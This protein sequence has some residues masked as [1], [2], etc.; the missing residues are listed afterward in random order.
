MPP[1]ERRKKITIQAGQ[2]CPLCREKV[3]REEVLA[4]CPGCQAVYHRD[5]SGELASGRCTTLGCRYSQ[6]RTASGRRPT[7]PVRDERPRRPAR[8]PLTSSERILRGATAC[9]VTVAFLFLAIHVSES[10]EANSVK[11]KRAKRHALQ[12]KQVREVLGTYRLR[13]KALRALAE[14]T[15]PASW[16]FPRGD[17]DFD[18]SAEGTD[19]AVVSWR[20]LSDPSAEAPLDEYFPRGFREGLVLSTKSPE[21]PDYPKPWGLSPWVKRAMFVRFVVAVRV[22]SLQPA[23]KDGQKAYAVLRAYLFD[24][25]TDPSYKGCLEVRGGAIRYATDSL[26]YGYEGNHYRL[27]LRESTGEGL[28]PSPS[29]T[30]CSKA[31]DDAYRELRRELGITH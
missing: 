9:G 17:F 11:E 6:R 30:A 24:L 8:P 10:I 26:P 29:R 15:P 31:L 18:D 2:I 1:S 19:A 4:V 3:H 25:D 22:H 20:Q 5:C 27:L 23:K 12:A 7:A 28:D 14:R 16:R 13:A 21:S